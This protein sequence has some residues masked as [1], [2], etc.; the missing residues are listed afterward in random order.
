ML[1]LDQITEAIRQN[2]GNIEFI[3]FESDVDGTTENEQGPWSYKNAS[4]C[5]VMYRSGDNEERILLQNM[6]KRGF[7]KVNNQIKR[8]KY[9]ES[10]NSLDQFPPRSFQYHERNARLQDEVCE[11]PSLRLRANNRPNYSGT[12][13]ITRG[14]D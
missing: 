10:Q 3:R 1:H 2:D 5:F 14:S 4:K 6:I 7:P 8:F 11:K 13:G 9:R 12:H